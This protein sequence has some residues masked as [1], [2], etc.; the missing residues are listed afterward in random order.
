NDEPVAGAVM[1]TTGLL[2]PEPDI[3][4]SISGAL[5]AS[6]LSKVTCSPLVPVRRM[7]YA[8]PGDV[9]QPCTMEVTSIST[10]VPC[11][12][13]PI[14][15]LLTAGL[16]AGRVLCVTEPSD[17]GPCST[18]TCTLPAERRSCTNSRSVAEATLP[19]KADT[20]KAA[21]P[22]FSPD[23]LTRRSEWLP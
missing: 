16:K 8:V 1:V 5:A 7:P 2:L 18:C 15:R 4:T 6:R 13:T 3:S 11:C 12:A 14:G 9:C 20:S 10:V 17:Q 22:T 21:R 23:W 19:D